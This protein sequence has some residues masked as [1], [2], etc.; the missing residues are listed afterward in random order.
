LNTIIEESEIII[1]IGVESFAK[2]SDSELDEEESL[3]PETNSD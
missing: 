3:A 2:S 1:D